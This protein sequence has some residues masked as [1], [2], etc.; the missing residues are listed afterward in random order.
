MAEFPQ[1]T[2]WI[3]DTDLPEHQWLKEATTAIADWRA[4]FRSTY[5]RWALAINGLEQAAR[6]YSDPDWIR[7]KSFTISSLRPDEAGTRDAEG[8]VRVITKVIATWDGRTA[9]EN[10]L[11]TMPML[12]Q[13]GIIDVYARS[14]EFVFA[15]CTGFT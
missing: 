6:R 13:F 7:W 14:E 3:V 15:L 4:R 5:M 12:A 11:A 10:H 1:F 8:R 2:N 9:A